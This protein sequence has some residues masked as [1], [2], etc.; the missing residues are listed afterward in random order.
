MSD[1]ILNLFGP[2]YLVIFGAGALCAFSWFALQ[3]L[4]SYRY[5]RAEKQIRE[6]QRKLEPDIAEAWDS[7]SWEPVSY[8]PKVGRMNGR[9]SD[10]E[11]HGA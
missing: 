3:V 10:R 11:S 8:Q 1:T 6:L 5:A 7:R 9:L 2:L 4:H